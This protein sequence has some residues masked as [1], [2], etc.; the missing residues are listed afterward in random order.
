MTGGLNN[1]FSEQISKIS[2]I[3]INKIFTNSEIFSGQARINQLKPTTQQKNVSFLLCFICGPIRKKSSFIQVL[4][5]AIIWQPARPCMTQE[6]GSN[7]KRVIL[8]FLNY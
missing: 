3:K 4:S 8:N 6:D 2:I 5:H 1:Y 7:E